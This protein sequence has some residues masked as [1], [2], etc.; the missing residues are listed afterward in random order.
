MISSAKP[1][2]NIFLQEA[3]SLLC[4][5]FCIKVNKIIK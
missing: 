5:S 2:K 1:I 3:L 4:R